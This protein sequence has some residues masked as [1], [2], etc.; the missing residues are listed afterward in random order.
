MEHSCLPN[1][2]DQAVNRLPWGDIPVDIIAWY[3]LAQRNAR[4]ERRDGE[5]GR[6]GLLDKLKSS[7]L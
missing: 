1:N 3:Q 2:K 6:G 4:E 7:S 5:R